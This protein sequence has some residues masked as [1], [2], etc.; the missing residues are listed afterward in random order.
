MLLYKVNIF[1]S[2]SIPQANHMDF[3]IPSKERI[4]QIASWLSETP[5]HF[6]PTAA[7][8]AAWLPYADTPEAKKIIAQAESVVGT[9]IPELP[10]ELYL[11]FLRIGNRSN[12]ERVYFQRQR[13]RLFP[14]VQAEVLEYKG[15]FLEAIE[16]ELNAFF[17]EKSWVLPAHDGDL[18]N[19]NGTAPY[20]DLFCSDFCATLAIYDWWLQD[21]LQPTTRK[22]IREE[23][24]R[25]MFAAYRHV[26]R[27]G[28]ITRGQWWT[29][30]G[31][32]WN[33]VC[34]SQLVIA[35]MILMEDRHDRAEILA[36]VEKAMPFF[37]AGY[38]ADGY[39]TE[40]MGYWGYGYGR[41]L[42]LAET[43]LMMTGG[44][45]SLYD[46]ETLHNVAAFARD[47]QIE[48]NC[49]PAFADC[50]VGISPSPDDIAI[51]QYRYPDAVLRAFAVLTNGRI[52]PQACHWTGSFRL[53]NSIRS[54]TSTSVVPP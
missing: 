11:Q 54:P 15:R 53:A 19:F 8:R 22:R 10:D 32:N 1:S 26:I 40:G 2:Q 50:G 24:E 18:W 27:T 33:S 51:I 45:L 12:Y 21:K 14:L 6:G 38:S 36:A 48:E 23:V 43:V 47:I 25:R 52:R 42:I 17:N 7:D 44:K 29:V 3:P 4:D 31:N 41:F 9:P 13:D 30:G 35:A 20:A 16:K 34:H 28:E 39:C 46:N 49:C 37:T 5:G